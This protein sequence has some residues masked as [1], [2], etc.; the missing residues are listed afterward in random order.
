GS[1][2]CWGANGAS[3]LGLPGETHAVAS[4]VMALAPDSVL[5]AGEGHTCVADAVQGLFC[6]GVNDHAQLGLGAGTPVIVAAPT[7]VELAGAITALAAGPD[8]T[9]AI[10]GGEVYCWG[11]S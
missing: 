7:H 6:F 5:A 4:R 9:C 10:A 8:H 11:D 2:Y 1:L 3:Q